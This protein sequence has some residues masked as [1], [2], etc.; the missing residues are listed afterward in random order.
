MVVLSR[1]VKIDQYFCS[2]EGITYKCSGPGALLSIPHDG[3][4]EDIIRNKVF[5]DYIRNNVAS[6]FDWS[7]KNGLDVERMEDLVLVTGCTLVTSWAAAA[8][9][10]SSE[11]S[12][13]ERPHQKG[14]SFEF[15]NIRGTVAQ[16]SSR[17]DTVRP[18]VMFDRHALIHFLH[19]ERE[20]QVRLRISASSL[21][22]SERS[23]VYSGQ[24]TY[25][26]QQNPFLTIPTT[27][28][29]MRSK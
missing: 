23:A 12:L 28:V 14:T 3:H 25:G 22:A 4:S 29:R 10:D 7:Q 5:E 8:F 13:I 26:L 9:L 2:A 20:I 16:H 24:N 21:G 18:A 27:V 11:F 6:W 17:F 15:N 19:V 1:T